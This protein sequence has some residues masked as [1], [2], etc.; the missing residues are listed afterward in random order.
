[1]T[2]Y[3]NNP[4]AN[5]ESV[6]AHSLPN[7]NP[8]P[9]TIKRIAVE[10]SAIT[11]KAIDQGFSSGGTIFVERAKTQNPIMNKPIKIE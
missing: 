8:A 5:G 3:N 7:H 10:N 2:A 9:E 1:M 6:L 11:W 4:R